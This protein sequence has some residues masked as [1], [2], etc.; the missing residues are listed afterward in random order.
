MWKMSDRYAELIS[1]KFSIS[2]TELKKEL[3]PIFM[4]QSKIDIDTFVDKLILN[5]KL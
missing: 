3:E 1:E 4:N 5:F 2:L